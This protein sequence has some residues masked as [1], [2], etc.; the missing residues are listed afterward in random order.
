MAR[1]QIERT[2]FAG[3]VGLSCQALDG[4]CFKTSVHILSYFVGN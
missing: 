1:T 2:T 3:I 4:C